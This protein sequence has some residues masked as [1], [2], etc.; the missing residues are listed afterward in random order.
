MSKT[1]NGFPWLK[2]SAVAGSI[3]LG[4][5]Y[6]HLDDWKKIEISPLENQC[7]G[8]NVIVVNPPVEEPCTKYTSESEFQLCTDPKDN[9]VHNWYVF[10]D[11]ICLGSKL[12]QEFIDENLSLEK[13]YEAGPDTYCLGPNTLL[14]DDQGRIDF[15]SPYPCDNLEGFL[16]VVSYKVGRVMDD[17]FEN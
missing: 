15:F 12:S 13:D 17:F 1:E 16:G 11:T 7:N 14:L 5:G 3:I 6:C 10:E 9:S 8:I 4:V 2:A